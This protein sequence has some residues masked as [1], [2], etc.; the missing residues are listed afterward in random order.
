MLLVN[1]L[2][3]PY[4]ASESGASGR[5]TRNSTHHQMEMDLDGPDERRL[6][7]SSGSE[8]DESDE[9][10][11]AKDASSGDDNHNSAES[12]SVSEHDS[13]RSLRLILKFKDPNLLRGIDLHS[14]AGDSV[15]STHVTNGMSQA[16]IHDRI[17]TSEEQKDTA[18]DTSMVVNASDME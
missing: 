6:A 7:Q 4:T 2:E 18:G 11:D 8:R 9:N 1:G 15:D 12:Y 3:T 10:Y 5:A 14:E 13:P 17:E 16:T